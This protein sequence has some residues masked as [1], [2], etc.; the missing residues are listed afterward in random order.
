[1]SATLSLALLS[2][3]ASPTAPTG[4]EQSLALLAEGLK[5]R[6]HRVHVVAPGPWVLEERLRSASIEVHRI[7]CSSCWLV[8]DTR[9]WTVRT[10]WR[11]ARCVLPDAGTA[12]LEALLRRIGL[13]VVHVNCLP[14][15]RG[16]KAARNAGLPVVWHLREIMPPGRRRQWF[17]K[18][19]RGDAD[20]LVAVSEAVGAWVRAEGLAERM[21]VVPNGV[22]VTSDVVDPVSARRKLG[23]PEDG[24]LVGLFGQMLPHK[25]VVEFVRAGSLALRQEPGLRFVLAGDGPDGFLGKVRSEMAREDSHARFHLLPAQ[26]SG[27]V[28]VAAADVVCLPS[29]R[30]DPLP[31]TVLEAMAVGRA[32]TGF[33]SGGTAEMVVE[34][35]TGLLTHVGDVEGLAASFVRLARDEPLR[36]RMG[37][38]AR[39]RAG[40]VFS[41]ETHVDR[42]EA[43]LR[44]AAAR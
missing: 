12:K 32:V 43:V 13:D 6:G 16:A 9:T 18:R 15:V 39:R 42:M 44:E 10:A 5:R 14:H 4:A 17:A 37:E 21:K 29:T 33:R 20:A 2:H 8:H 28:L 31:R 25:G 23:L 24:C 34:G 3:L 27:D 11:W 41:I 35:T 40:E 1:M 22:A 7:R 26:P 36:R 19:L 30:P 38:E